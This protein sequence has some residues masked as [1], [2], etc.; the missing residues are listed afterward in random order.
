ME[1]PLPGVMF[2]TADVARLGKQPESVVRRLADAG[3]LPHA[4]VGKV[5]VFAPSDLEAIL[6]VLSEL[7]AR[8]VPMAL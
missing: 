5:R 3:R 6:A 7:P 8:P 1:V 4:R 2:G